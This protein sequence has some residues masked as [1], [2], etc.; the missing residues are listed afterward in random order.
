[1]R[2]NCCI[3]RGKIAKTQL[4]GPR[5]GVLSMLADY[6][7]RPMLSD[8]GPVSAGAV[9]SSSGAPVTDAATGPLCLIH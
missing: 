5:T 4:F 2:N 6:D 3:I 7:V 9:A 8:R 1:M